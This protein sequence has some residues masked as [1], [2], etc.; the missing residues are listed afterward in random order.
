MTMTISGQ[1]DD[2]FI[3][4]WIGKP[5]AVQFASPL[6][7]GKGSLR[8]RLRLSLKSV[9]HIEPAVWRYDQ[10]SYGLV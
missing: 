4:L 3:G 10:T 6:C 5:G 7:F 1:T 9:S 8:L 2:H